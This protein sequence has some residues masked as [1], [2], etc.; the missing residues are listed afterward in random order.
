MMA[1]RTTTLTLLT[2]FLAGCTSN[3]AWYGKEDDTVLDSHQQTVAAGDDALKRSV[4]DQTK[5]G[6]T[7]LD[8]S[9]EPSLKETAEKARDRL[10]S[11]EVAD[12]EVAEEDRDLWMRIRAGFAMDHDQGDERMQQQLDWYQKHP[13]Y[14]KR[15]VERGRRYLYYIVEEIEHRGLP[16]E[17]ALLPVVESAFDP[18]AYSHGRASGLWQF[19]PGTGRHFGLD[20]SWWHDDR[21]DVLASTNAAL[22]YLDQLAQRFDGDPTLALAAYNSG[23]GTVS[24]AIRRNNRKGEPT[25]YWSLDLPRETRHYVPKLIALAKIFDDPEAYGIELPPLEDEPYF[26]VV[27]TGGQIDLAH[28]AELA[29]VDVDE[30]YLLNPSFNRWAT[31]PDGPHRLLVPVASADRF[32]QGIAALDP[33]SRVSWDHY[34]VRSGDNL[35]A[36]SRR[37]GT[38]VAVLREVNNLNSDIIR[39]GQ[40]L[41]IPSARAGKDTYSHSESQRIA[42]KQAQGGRNNDGQRVEYKV[43]RGDTFWDIAREHGVSVRQV[44]AW[45]GM[46]PGDPLVPGR[47]LVIWSKNADAASATQVASN[48][49]SG[50]VRKVGYRVRRGDSLSTIANRFAVNVSDIAAW[51]DLNT[52][53]YLQPGQ[54]LV[55]YVDVRNSP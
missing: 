16:M 32:R 43:T 18:F 51:N 31:R 34:Q 2:F 45:N 24:S 53:R 20:Q 29:G 15:V 9:I 46:A 30:I 17:Y 11:G 23:G 54:S 26:E 52:S 33:D 10:D 5:D 6:T 39:V 27:E 55:L 50:M 25:D 8:E 40:Q 21:R 22:T 28:A 38:T 35:G 14:V 1:K 48:N 4:E 41:L 47:K 44:A 42:R 13:A 36:I 19:I 7:E 49:R 12:G 37:H 3:S